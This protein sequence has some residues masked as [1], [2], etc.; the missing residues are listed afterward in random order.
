MLKDVYIV[1]GILNGLI[2]YLLYRQEF[3][4]KLFM[5]IIDAELGGQLRKENV[6]IGT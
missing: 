6:S 2:T 1:Y 5:Y 3:P 4:R